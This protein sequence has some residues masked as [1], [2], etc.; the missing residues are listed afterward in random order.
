MFNIAREVQQIFLALLEREAC[1][2]AWSTRLPALPGGRGGDVLNPC[3]AIPGEESRDSH[4]GARAGPIRAWL[5][6]KCAPYTGMT[7]EHLCLCGS[8][9][10]TPSE[11]I[12][13]K[14]LGELQDYY[15][16]KEKKNNTRQ[17]SWQRCVI[18]NRC[19]PSKQLMSLCKV[20]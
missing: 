15:S 12:L 8:S 4:N 11:P 19:T 6:P 5:S 18:T 17:E 13:H 14:H 20:F 10:L 1:G 3:A 7:P 9:S 16:K 2:T